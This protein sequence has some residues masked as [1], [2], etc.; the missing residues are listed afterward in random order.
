[1]LFA[2][3][4]PT[5]QWYILDLQ[6]GQER[7]VGFEDWGLKWLSEEEF[8]AGWTIV[9]VTDLSVR[10]LKALLVDENENLII[11]LE[12]LR[13]T[14]LVYLVQSTGGVSAISNDPA[15]PYAFYIGN[16]NYTQGVLQEKFP[17]TKFVV[18]A[19]PYFQPTAGVRNPGITQRDSI[20]ITSYYANHDFPSPDGRFYARRVS[21]GDIEI[22]QCGKKLVAHAVKSNWDMYPGGWAYDSSGF[23]FLLEPRQGWFTGDVTTSILKLNIP[24]EVLANAPPYEGEGFCE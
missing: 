5:S 15:Y 13:G 1:M 2:A 6:T 21:G 10:E 12:S 4:S 24:P 8:A 14:K 18:V 3:E 11:A 9:N 19:P 20:H 7:S 23:Y 17:E 16:R 22:Y